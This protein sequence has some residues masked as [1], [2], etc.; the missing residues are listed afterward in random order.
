ME[1]FQSHSLRIKKLPKNFKLWYNIHVEADETFTFNLVLLYKNSRKFI[2]TISV[3]KPIMER[4]FWLNQ[5]Y[6]DLFIWGTGA[7]ITRC[8]S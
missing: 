5:A 6:K 1:T 7:I 2:V 8:S 3:R 4:V